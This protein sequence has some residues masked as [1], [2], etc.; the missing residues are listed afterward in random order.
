[1]R[2]T[3]LNWPAVEGSGPRPISFDRVLACA[4]RSA[5][6]APRLASR[7]KFRSRTRRHG[8]AI[9]QR[10]PGRLPAV[11][12]EFIPAGKPGS[13]SRCRSRKPGPIKTKSTGRSSTAGQ[14]N[15]VPHNERC[16]SRL[17]MSPFVRARVV[18]RVCKMVSARFNDCFRLNTPRTHSGSSWAGSPRTRNARLHASLAV[19]NPAKQRRWN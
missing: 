17:P 15:A 12:N 11:A 2:R 13:N 19:D 10:S 3:A 6:I 5:R 4:D 18:E 16:L 7:D 8:Q 14:F 1:V 9:F